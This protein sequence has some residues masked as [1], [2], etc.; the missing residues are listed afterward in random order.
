L[1]AKERLESPKMGTSVGVGRKVP[2]TMA[3]I[4]KICPVDIICAKR[5][6]SVQGF[7]SSIQSP[8]F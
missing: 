5:N 8:V 1:G 3:F 6:T 2:F 4:A 7:A